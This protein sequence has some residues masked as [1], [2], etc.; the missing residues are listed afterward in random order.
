MEQIWTL[1]ESHLLPNF[2]YSA[3]RGKV[4]TQ[5]VWVATVEKS[6]YYWI[7]YPLSG[8]SSWT[9]TC[10]LA[11]SN[12]DSLWSYPVLFSRHF[13]ELEWFS[14]GCSFSLL[15]FISQVLQPCSG[16]ANEKSWHSALIHSWVHLWLSEMSIGNPKGLDLPSRCARLMELEPDTL[17]WWSLTESSPLWDC[18]TN[19][20]GSEWQPVHMWVLLSQCLAFKSKALLLPSDLQSLHLTQKMTQF[21]SLA[22]LILIRSK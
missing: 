22:L 7:C 11:L 3:W 16:R 19:C 10:S 6:P 13:W 4:F 2:L 14:P 15:S 12:R 21:M 17:A 18:H 8:K 9:A 20:V 5:Q 1:S